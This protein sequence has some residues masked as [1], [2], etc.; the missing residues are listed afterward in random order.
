M[1]S[2][3]QRGSAPP[4]PHSR[5]YVQDELAAVRRQLQKLSARHRRLQEQYNELVDELS[6]LDPHNDVLVDH[7]LE[8]L[9]G[10]PA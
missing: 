8:D 3:I 7:A 9:G 4:L 10:E 6:K 5:R 2:L 1:P